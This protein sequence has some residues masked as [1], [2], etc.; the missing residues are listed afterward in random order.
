LQAPLESF[1]NPTWFSPEA[2]KRRLLKKRSDRHARELAR[3]VDE[4]KAVI[5]QR[6]LIRTRT[7]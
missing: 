3:V 5:S 7:R 1:R 6:H 2:S 4:A